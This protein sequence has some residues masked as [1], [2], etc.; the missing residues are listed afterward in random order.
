MGDQVTY[1]YMLVISLYRVVWRVRVIA[2]HLRVVNGE[3][4]MV[5]RVWDHF[6]DVSVMIRCPGAWG[7]GICAWL[8]IYGFRCVWIV[9]YDMGDVIWM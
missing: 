3:V 5:N 6:R 1:E 8:C 7:V 2:L 9:V 4:D